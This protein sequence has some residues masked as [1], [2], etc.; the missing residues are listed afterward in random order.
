[1]DLLEG[2][3]SRTTAAKLKA[4]GPTREHIEHII[5]AAVHAPDHGRLRPWRFVV[6][7][8]AARE[9]L[10]DAMAKKLVEKLPDASPD[11]LENERRKALR[12]PTIIV[13]AARI[14]KSG[15]IPEI[16]Q[17]EAVTAAVQNML[18]AAHALGYGAMWKTG[19]AAYDPN[20]KVMLGLAPE[21]HVVALLYVG[22]IE[23]PGQPT[24]RS[25]DGIVSWMD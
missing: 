20:I 18:L 16:E 2:I 24:P 15:K 6:L 17:I 4:P 3:R 14:T 10:G 5:G 22:T 12:A 23:A 13:A 9:R 7:Q 1:M 11:Q 21:D 8:G 25:I 19:P